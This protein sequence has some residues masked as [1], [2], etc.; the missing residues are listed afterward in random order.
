[1][2]P[3]SDFLQNLSTAKHEYQ[4]LPYVRLGD[5]YVRIESAAPVGQYPWWVPSSGFNRHN[6]SYQDIRFIADIVLRLRDEHP[7]ST[8][9]PARHQKKKP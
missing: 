1:M 2:R 7:Y 9:P 3:N 5:E 8:F 6:T 4:I